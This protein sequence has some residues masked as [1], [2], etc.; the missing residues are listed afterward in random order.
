MSKV[1]T[2]SKKVKELSPN[3][4]LLLV[5]IHSLQLKNIS[6]ELRLQR[7]EKHFDQILQHINYPVNNLAWGQQPLISI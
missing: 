2:P 6:L 4:T 1:E 5:Q 3:E 7:M